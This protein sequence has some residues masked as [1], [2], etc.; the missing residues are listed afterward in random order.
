MG[1][2]EVPDIFYVSSLIHFTITM[3]GPVTFTYFITDKSLK[4]HHSPCPDPP[5]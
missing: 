1:I 4:S 2:S 5:W 3:Y